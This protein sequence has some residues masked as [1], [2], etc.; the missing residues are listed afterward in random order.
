MAT[1]PELKEQLNKGHE[2]SRQWT[3]RLSQVQQ[4]TH[5]TDGEIDNPIIRAHQ[6]VADRIAQHAK[7]PPSAT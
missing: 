6:E 1:S 5:G 7:D 3:E 2:Y 4:T